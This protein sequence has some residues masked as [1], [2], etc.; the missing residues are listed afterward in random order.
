MRTHQVLSLGLVVLGLALAGTAR[1]AESKLSPQRFIPAKGLVAYLEYDGLDA[2]TAAW[3]ASAAHGILVESHAGTMM[4]ELV[5]QLLDRMLREYP[6]LK[7]S[8]S[9]IVASHTFL[10]HHGFVIA[11]HEDGDV[12]S[13]TVVLNGVGEKPYR[14]RFERWIASARDAKASGKPPGPVRVR[15]RDVFIGQPL[16]AGPPAQPESART[17]WWFEG[18]ELVIVASSPARLG[19]PDGPVNKKNVDPDSGGHVRRVLD[20]IDE[21]LSDITTRADYLSARNEGGDIPGFEPNGLL[22]IDLGDKKNIALSELLIAPLDLSMGLLDVLVSS[23]VGRKAEVGPP[24]ATVPVNTVLPGVVGPVA[25]VDGPPVGPPGATLP[26]L[27]PPP[28]APSAPGVVCDLPPSAPSAAG[29]VYGPPSSAPSAAGAVYGPPS[30]APS[31]AGAVYGPPSSAPSATAPVYGQPPTLPPPGI[32]YSAVI[33]PSDLPDDVFLPEVDSPTELASHAVPAESAK[34]QPDFGKLF[35][36]NGIHRLVVRWGFQSKALLTLVRV[37]APAP[38][39]GL[40]ALLDQPRFRKGHLPPIPEG[41]RSFAVGSFDASG[42][43][44]RIAELLKALDPDV[45]KEILQAERAIREALGL[46]GSDDLRH[47][48][49]LWSVFRLHS[50]DDEGRSGDE[51][52]PSEYALVAGIDSV[53]AIGTVLDSIAS[54][55]NQYFVEKEQKDAAVLAIE[56]LKAPGRGYRLTSPARLVPWLSDDLSPTILIGRSYVVLAANLERAREALAAEVPAGNRWSPGGELQKAL[57][58]LPENLTFLAVGDH[59]DSPW[60]TLFERLPAEIQLMASMLGS[61]DG[62]G[63]TA[64]SEFLAVLGIPA[65]GGFRF[66]IDPAQIPRAE[67]VQRHLFPSVLA[68]TVD[69]RGFRLISREAF[70]F[71]CVG[72]SGSLKSTVTWKGAKGLDRDMKLKLNLL[73]LGQ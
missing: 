23:V 7:L 67:Q 49:S 73:G 65:P 43:Y 8:G 57:N 12:L 3:K 51:I 42:T 26:D 63:A 18:S 56:K 2:H 27:G 70:P 39:S 34:A 32:P 50:Q 5:R 15:G 53:D 13:V 37:E 45:A 68:T 25:T 64:G 46:R 4:S 20:A 14:G 33:P 22:L 17:A 24:R 30:S 40:V 6:D 29:A 69:D 36:L 55:F 1:S 58:C 72:G 48:G 21:K 54:K 60:P 41:T 62:A 59:R 28:S 47:L 66:R 11:V 35:G 61:L 9:D 19:S 16:D 38:R 31:A 52:D 44:A 10:M 71:A